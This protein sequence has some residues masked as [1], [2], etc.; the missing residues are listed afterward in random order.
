MKVFITYGDTSFEAAKERIVEEAKRTGVF[1][2]V[3]A[4][5]REDLSEELLN[6]DIIKVRRG[7]GLWSW[8]P[9]ILL[10]T[11]QQ[12]QDG[13]LLVYCDAGCTLYCSK[14]WSCIWQKLEHHDLIAQRIF[15]RTD[16]WTRRELL[17]AFA[18]DCGPGWP[19]CY[20]YQATII[21]KISPFTRR[22]V[23]EWRELMITKPLLASDV[24]EQ[25][26]I[27]QHSTFIENRH[28]QAIYSAIVYKYLRIPETAKKIYTQWEHIENLD[29]VY[30]Q[31]IRATRLRQGETET[32]AH[33]RKAIVKRCIK[34]YIYKPF[35]YAPLQWWY[36]RK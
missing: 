4:F 9:D 7:G 3:R 23:R 29:I 21:L 25:E 32:T 33:R 27:M 20:Q 12:C 1:D 30:P 16:Q 15:Q 28:D 24:N 26:R 10:T 19:K 36:N 34:D 2:I 11:M 6:S 22:L 5:G 31:A 17:E 18:K 35:Y 13:D 14:E 8:K